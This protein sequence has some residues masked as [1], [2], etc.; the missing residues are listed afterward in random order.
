MN[1]EESSD[2]CICVSLL[3][4]KFKGHTLGNGHDL[5]PYP[6]VMPAVTPPKCKKIMKKDKARSLLTHLVRASP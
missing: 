1:Y 4:A 5:N 2:S 6:W 3:F